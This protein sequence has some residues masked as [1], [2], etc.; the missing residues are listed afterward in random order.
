MFIN[1]GPQIKLENSKRMQNSFYSIR[2]KIRSL[3]K[4]SAVKNSSKGCPFNNI[5]HEVPAVG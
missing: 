4:K 1:I 5:H 2:P 3:M